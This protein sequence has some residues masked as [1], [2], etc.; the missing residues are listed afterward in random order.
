[1]SGND[2]YDTNQTVFFYIYKLGVGSALFTSALHVA[3]SLPVHNFNFDFPFD[4]PLPEIAFSEQTPTDFTYKTTGTVIIT[5]TPSPVSIQNR[6][7]APIPAKTRNYDYKCYDILG[8]D[9]KNNFKA[10]LP[11]ISK[12]KFFIKLK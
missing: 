5:F 6:I 4:F 12:N 3:K 9:I 7:A 11:Y 8:R 2:W 1:M 10:N